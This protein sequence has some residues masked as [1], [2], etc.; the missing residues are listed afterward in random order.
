MLLLC[1]PLAPS[2]PCWPI[3]R[4]P[5]IHLCFCFQ[6]FHSGSPSQTPGLGSTSNKPHK[7]WNYQESLFF[8]ISGEEVPPGPFQEGFP[9]SRS[10]F[11][12]PGPHPACGSTS[13]FH[14][15]L[16]PRWLL[17]SNTTLLLSLLLLGVWGLV[18]PSN[19]SLLQPFQCYVIW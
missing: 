19:I 2:H 4:C 8:M 11:R 17:P 10:R 1:V 3:G 16:L 13:H 5:L 18:L 9:L 12:V 7:S 6:Q 14:P 15:L